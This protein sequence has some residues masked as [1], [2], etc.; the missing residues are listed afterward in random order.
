M[1]G[2]VEERKS[3]LLQKTLKSRKRHEEGRRKKR[4]GEGVECLLTL[5]SLLLFY[6]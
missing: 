6:L 4:E 2:F 5:N 1:F 3:E